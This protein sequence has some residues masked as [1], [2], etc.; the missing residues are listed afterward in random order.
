MNNGERQDTAERH[1][2]TAAPYRPNSLRP[3]TDTSSST[4]GA[5]GDTQAV[6]AQLYVLTD[7]L[8]LTAVVFLLSLKIRPQ[9]QPASL[10]D[11]Y[12]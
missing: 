2:G 12:R 4:P 9:V 6:A 5:G 7:L 3:R 8:R 10:S 1:P 11:S